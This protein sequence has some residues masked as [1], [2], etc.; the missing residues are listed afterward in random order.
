MVY[1]IKT[2]GDGVPLSSLVD[3]QQGG[4]LA[5]VLASKPDARFMMAGSGGYGF[6]ANLADMN[7]RI[8]TGKVFITLEADETLLLP[9][10]IA[11]NL[12]PEKMAFLCAADNGRV[13]C[14]PLSELKTLSKGRGL[15]LMQLAAGERLCAMALLSKHGNHRHPKQ[16]RQQQ[17]THHRLA[18]RQSSRHHRARSSF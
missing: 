11:A 14:F 13:L 6:M 4:Q 9:H 1:R 18:N 3:F 15:M 12:A 17:P 8:K 16:R 5:Y 10:P 2:R 7:S